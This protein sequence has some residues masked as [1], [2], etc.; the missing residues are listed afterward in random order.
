M[1]HHY[2]NP[3][4]SRLPIEHKEKILV[5]QVLPGKRNRARYT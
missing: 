5:L 1:I 4:S 2:A 3:L